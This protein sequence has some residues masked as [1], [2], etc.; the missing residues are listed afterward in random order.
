VDAD[1][2]VWLLG[3]FTGRL[4]AVIDRETALVLRGVP[5]TWSICGARVVVNTHGAA[6]RF[7]SDCVNRVGITA[8]MTGAA[9]STEQPDPLDWP[10]PPAS[11]PVPWSG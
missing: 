10:A 4:H 2:P 5:L 6:G 1:D 11:D 8:L 9:P 3:F 7:C